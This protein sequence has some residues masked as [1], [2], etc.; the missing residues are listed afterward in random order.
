MEYAELKQL[1]E[2]SMLLG[3]R[4]MT[5]IIEMI[6]SKDWEPNNIIIEL[7]TDEEFNKLY[8]NER[9]AFYQLLHDIKNNFAVNKPKAIK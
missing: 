7:V 3:L 4:T 8:P 9:E 6:D 5:G 1:E 2:D